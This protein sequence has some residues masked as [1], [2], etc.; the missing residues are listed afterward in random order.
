M[1]QI[2]LLIN[3]PLKTYKSGYVL[4]L[5]ACTDGLPEDLYWRARI[6]DAK[7]DDCVTII[8]NTKKQPE[9]ELSEPEL[10]KPNITKKT[11]KIGDKHAD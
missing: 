5:K 2:K 9:T 4:S 6:K 10:Q 11:K 8:K 7:Y 1:K 3:K